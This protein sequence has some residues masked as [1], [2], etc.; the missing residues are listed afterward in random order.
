MWG[1]VE[2]MDWEG[3]RVVG[4]FEVGIFEVGIFEVG[5]SEV[6]MLEVGIFE[7]GI[8]GVRTGGYDDWEFRVIG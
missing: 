4:I 5:T 2:I 6:G 8:L 3:K 1:P 7:V